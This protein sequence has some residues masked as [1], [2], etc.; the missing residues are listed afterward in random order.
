MKNSQQTKNR[1]KLKPVMSI[2]KILA[3]SIILKGERLK[4]F[5]LRIRN[6]TKIYT[7][8]TFIQHYT[9]GFMQTD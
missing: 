7:L 1:R 3:V 4:A 9:G 2:Y 8:A 6:K 5:L